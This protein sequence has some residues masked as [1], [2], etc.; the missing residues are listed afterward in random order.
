MTWLG[1]YVAQHPAA[2]LFDNATVFLD[3]GTEVQP[4]AVLWRPE[5]GGARLTDDGYI[6]GAP[7]LI[8]E[9]AA[10]SVSYDLHNKKEAYRRNGVREYVVWRV[11]EQ[12]IDWFHLEDGQYVQV[13]PDADGVI[14]SAQFPGLR[15]D[16]PRM[17]A[18]DLAAVLSRVSAAPS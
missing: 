8:V 17:L 13:Q 14:E 2:D 11:I 1:L 12:A 10:S 3:D 7:Q 18:G 15:L 16:V 9:V 4:D 6:E 5:P